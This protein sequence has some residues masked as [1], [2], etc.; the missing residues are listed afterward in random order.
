AAIETVWDGLVTP[1]KGK[2]ISRKHYPSGE[3]VL[4][5]GQEMG[6]FNMGSTVI[7]VMESPSPALSQS[8]V[9]GLPVKMGQAIS[10]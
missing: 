1:P 10:A 8:L 7:L 5:K 4:D 2:S 3:V 6:R 9:E